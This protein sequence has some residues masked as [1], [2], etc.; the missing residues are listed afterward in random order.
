MSYKMWKKI[1]ETPL[2]TVHS[3]EL[4]CTTRRRVC[5]DASGSEAT[6]GHGS[7]LSSMPA[8]MFMI[9]QVQYLPWLL[10]GCLVIKQNDGQIEIW[11]SMSG[12]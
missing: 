2:N 5:R 1:Q 9:M 3:K 7:A 12:K 11:R 8:N 10:Q 4:H 6:L